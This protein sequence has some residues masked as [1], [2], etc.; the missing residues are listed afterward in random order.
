MAT[1]PRGTLAAVV[2]ENLELKPLSRS[3]I[4]GALE[5]AAHY[6]LLNDPGPAES[7]CLDVLAVE[8]ESQE[9]LR[10]LILSIA[11]QFGAGGS[12]ASPTRAMQYV[13]QLTAKY[14]QHYYG[15]LVHERH[16]RAYLGRGMARGFAYGAFRDAMDEYEQAQALSAPGIEDAILRWNSCV[17]AIRREKLEPLSEARELQLE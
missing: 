11:D 17:R 12:G 14:D 5:K 6:R 9:G 15:G 16:A 8:P 1:D 7:I 3:A 4:R 13:G 10:L 2:T